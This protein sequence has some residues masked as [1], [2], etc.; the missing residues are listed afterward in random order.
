[1]KVDFKKVFHSKT[2]KIVVGVL[3]LVAVFV[4][5]KELGDS[6]DYYG[7]YAGSNYY[8]YDY[9]EESYYVEA[10]SIMSKSEVSYDYLYALQASTDGTVVDVD[11]ADFQ[12][13]MIIKTGYLEVEVESTIEAMTQV[14]DAAKVFGG[15][16]E[17]SY[18]SED[19]DG[20]MYGSITFRVPVDQ[21]DSAL[22]KVKEFS[23]T[24]SYESVD[25][26]DVTE[27]YIDITARL[28]TKYELEQ[29]YL[30][31]LDKA[32]TTTEILEVYSYLQ[33]VRA[34]IESL[35]SS[36]Q[37]YENQASYSTIS[38]YME[39][40]VSVFVPTRDWK[41]IE[42]V[43]TAFQNWIKFLEK[44]VNGIIWLAVYL[45]PLVIAWIGWKLVRRIRRRK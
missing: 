21:F 6:D 10:E 3:I 22:A 29:Q 11:A 23:D 20:S 27:D 42:V 24:V 18:T 19:V 40:N 35:E 15:Y 5:G 44:C 43:K 7:G 41:P 14:S 31:V 8:D 17:S 30:S 16:V 38:V 28:N 2:F 37:Y 13:S 12:E 39:E 4:G 32:T 34:D 36:K 26:Q 25:A 9:A 1:M 33:T 45:W